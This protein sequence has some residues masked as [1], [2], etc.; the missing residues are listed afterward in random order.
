MGEAA[1]RFLL[2]A[3]YCDPAF[4]ACVVEA[5]STQ[6]LVDQFCRLYGS[7]LDNDKRTEKDMRA[8]SEFVHDCIYTRLPDEAIHSLRAAALSAA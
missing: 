3:A 8:F 2:P 1:P 7:D 6:E 4:T 5:A